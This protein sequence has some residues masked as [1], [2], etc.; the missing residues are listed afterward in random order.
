[1]RAFKA[2]GLKHDPPKVST[3]PAGLFL[4]RDIVWQR[5]VQWPGG[6]TSACSCLHAVIPAERLLDFR[7][8][9]QCDAATEFYV[10]FSYKKGKGKSNTAS[11][12][13]NTTIWHFFVVP[14]TILLI[15]RKSL[16]SSP[17]GRRHVSRERWAVNVDSSLVASQRSSSSCRARATLRL[18]LRSYE[19]GGRWRMGYPCGMTSMK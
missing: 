6:R 10:L 5:D 17:A 11:L 8:S 7:R 18:I 15:P 13:P 3:A 2:R 14:K 12:Y 1:M 19:F 16:Q 4:H 9:V